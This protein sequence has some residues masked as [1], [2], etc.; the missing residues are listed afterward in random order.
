MSE[1][2]FPALTPAPRYHLDV[3]GYVV[4]EHTLSEDEVSR[5]L[6]AMFQAWYGQEPS[7]GFIEWIP[8]RL[9]P[10]ISGSDK[11]QWQRRSRPLDMQVETKEN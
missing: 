10:I 8:E 7:P 5:M 3:N 6:D 4:I 1:R 11:W 2:P 9:K